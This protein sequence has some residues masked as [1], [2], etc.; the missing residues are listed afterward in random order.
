MCPCQGRLFRQMMQS[1]LV[2]QLKM[3]DL[4]RSVFIMGELFFHTGAWKNFPIFFDYLSKTVWRSWQ[5]L[6]D[7]WC[8]RTDYIQ[9]SWSCLPASW[10]LRNVDLQYLP[11]FYLRFMSLYWRSC[12]K[13][14]QSIWLGQVVKAARNKPEQYKHVSEQAE[15]GPFIME[16]LKWV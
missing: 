4:S 2:Q 6:C 14:S 12:R 13:G 15:L 9:H 16:A 5:K 8:P 10:K 1:P 3:A 7:T 11:S